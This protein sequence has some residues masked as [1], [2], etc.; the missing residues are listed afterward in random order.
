M[1][2]ISALGLAGEP[3]SKIILENLSRPG[4]SEPVAGFDLDAIFIS[5]T[6]ETD[7]LRS[8]TL[9]AWVDDHL[10]TVK[11]TQV[12]SNL[13]GTVPELRS[14]NVFRPADNVELGKVD[15][16]FN[17]ET[18]TAGFISIG[19]GGRLEIDIENYVI[20][21]TAYLHLVD[22][23]GAGNE[24]LAGAS[25]TESVILVTG[26]GQDQDPDQPDIK[27]STTLDEAMTT[28]V[29]SRLV[30]VLANDSPA[31]LQI[32]SVSPPNFGTVSV[33][34]NQV[35]YTPTIEGFEG[36][37]TKP[38]YLATFTY[39]ALLP[40]GAPI[41]GTV[42]IEVGR[43]PLIAEEARMVAYTYEAGLNRNGKIDLPGL[44]FWILLRE[45][46]LTEEQ[47]AL[48]F[49]KSAE[50][51]SKFGS[52]ESLSDFDFVTVLYE[53]VLDRM[54][55]DAGRDFW[56]SVLAL[57]N[58]DRGDL[59]L[60][61]A[62]SNE[63][64]AGSVFVETLTK[65]ADGSWSFAL[66]DFT[67]DIVS[68]DDQLG[69][70]QKGEVTLLLSNLGGADSPKSINLYAVSQDVGDQPATVL[71]NYSLPVGTVSPGSDAT[72]V[73]DF[74][75][76]GSF[77]AGSYTFYAVVDPGDLVEEI[78]DGNNTSAFSTLTISG[79]P[80]INQP[81][82][83]SNGTFFLFEDSPLNASVGT[84]LASDPNDDLVGDWAILSGNEDWDGDGR[85]AFRISSS[86]GAI[87]VDD[88]DDLDF[89]LQS[90]LELTISA[91]DGLRSSSG[92]A[93]IDI[94]DVNELVVLPDSYEVFAGD[95]V[96]LDVLANDFDPDGDS[97]F[98]DFVTQPSQGYAFVDPF[99]FVGDVVVFDGFGAYSFLAEG[100]TRIETI[101]Y[102]VSDGFDFAFGEV[103][104]TIIGVG[105]GGGDTIPGNITTGETILPGFTRYERLD[106]LGDTDW[107]RAELTGGRTY[108]ID[109]RGDSFFGDPLADP[110]LGLY[111]ANGSFKLSNDDFDGFDSRLTYTPS[112]DETVY[113]SAE[114]Y[115]NSE[116]GDYELVITE[117]GDDSIPGDTSTLETLF[118][119][120]TRYERLDPEGDTDWFRLDLQAGQTYQIEL[121]GD[122]F[123]GDP[124]IDPFLGLYDAFGFFIDGNDD[125]EGQN[126]RLTYTPSFDETVYVSAEEFGNNAI[127]DYG[128]LVTNITVTSIDT[129]SGDTSTTETIS[130]GGVRYDTIDFNADTDWYRAELTGGRTYQI[131][132]VS[133]DFFGDPLIDPFLGLYDAAGIFIDGNHDF[134]GENSQ[135]IYTPSFD[136]TV[137]LSAEESGLD[138]TG[139]YA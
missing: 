96:E 109:L 38:G 8:I 93:T 52:Y 15:G 21:T 4:G 99:A 64:K 78:D 122:D 137:Y 127:G 10:D 117:V 80:D 103:Q 118:I 45:Q 12:D 77:G 135:L 41:E 125:F 94:G 42:K 27:I 17:G 13:A 101:E 98:I 105:G 79:T 11:L 25:P 23:S 112:V 111:D 44:N 51:T 65:G 6:R 43:A 138:A 58:I 7:L 50:F 83:V 2:E 87:F 121:F 86:T 129:I 90:Q 35:R 82:N 70:G 134:D 76:P 60:L 124:L 131:D 81:P 16:F 126:S 57:P 107:F 106:P 14:D 89:E 63:N 40:G 69:V 19:K 59:L 108:Q 116:I 66:P 33:E 104:L 1:A 88:P 54:A 3:L 37:F 132:L 53:S 5:N 95:I 55:D 9:E 123:F 67:V 31:G 100:E 61:F 49:L 29:Q 28:V 18:Q 24:T 47:M 36:D 114:A 110:F 119:D 120:F 136:E 85:S 34:D 73:R 56:L 32:L 39:T 68:F 20:P 22:Y 133:N 97:L 130:P 139:D 75:L 30:P 71:A 62:D 72:V 84:L 128:I 115:A 46:G 26:E 74:T 92:I 102:V 113:L 91:S 48:S